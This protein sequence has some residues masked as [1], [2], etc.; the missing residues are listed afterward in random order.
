MECGVK[1]PERYRFLEEQETNT[2]PRWGAGAAWMHFKE[3]PHCTQ[4]RSAQAG[5]LCKLAI[6]MSA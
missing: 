3:S 2:S 4:G 6:A 5:D 1:R